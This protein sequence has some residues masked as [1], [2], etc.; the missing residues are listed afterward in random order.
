MGQVSSDSKNVWDY[1]GEGN[2][3]NNYAGQDLNGDGIGDTPHV[4]DVNNKDNNPLMGRFS[5]FKVPW[6]DKT[7]HATTISNSTI[8][9][10][11]FEVGRETGNKIIRFDVTGENGTVGFCRVMIPTEL[12]DYP[13]VVLVDEEEVVSTLLDVS[14]ETHAHLYFT[15]LQSSHN[16]SVISSTL[17][18]LYNELLNNHAKLYTDFYNLNLTYHE[19]LENYAALLG[20]YSQLLESYGALNASY[21]QHLQDYL[22]LQA[23]HTSLLSE[24]AQNIQNLTYV[25]TVITAIFI[26]AA[27]YLST[28]AHRRTSRS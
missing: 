10:F 1:D 18:Y 24:H 22:E 5:D 13:Y 15:Y 12:M 9:N 27:V 11:K 28:H 6:K 26:I 14:N 16:I 20:N 8:S 2:Y 23:N 3:W 7:S 17:L 21:Q 25:F 4:I 19:L